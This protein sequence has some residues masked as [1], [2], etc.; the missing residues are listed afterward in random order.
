MKTATQPRK[1]TIASVKSFVKRNEGNLFIKVKSKFDGM[2]DGVVA[3][4]NR[5]QAVTPDIRNKEN[6]LGIAGA[7]FVG[8]SNDYL[9]E[10]NT[11]AFAGIE[12]TNSCG[13]FILAIGQ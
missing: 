13:S 10:Y 9:K 6:T 7:W 1:I 2:V 5:F 11:S 3:C 4:D 8:R 12:V